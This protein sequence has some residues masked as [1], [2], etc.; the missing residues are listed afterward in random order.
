MKRRNNPASV[1]NS[2][3]PGMIEERLPTVAGSYLLWFFLARRQPIAVGRL[4]VLEFKRGWYGY[5]GSACGPGGLKARLRHHLQVTIAKPHWHIDYFKQQASLRLIWLEQ[6][7]TREHQWSLQLE[8]LSGF[9]RP[10]PGFGASDCDCVSH[11]LYCPARARLQ[12]AATE[13]SAG[14]R[15]TRLRMP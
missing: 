13:L 15:L 11:L 5:C 3:L 9:S 12:A 7:A 14:G 8:Q 1:S 4:G 2:C 10:Y 6:N